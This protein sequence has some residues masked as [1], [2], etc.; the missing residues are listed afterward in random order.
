MCKFC[1][2]QSIVHFYDFRLWAIFFFDSVQHS[3][4]SNAENIQTHLPRQYPTRDNKKKT[5]HIYL[6]SNAQTNIKINI[7]TN[8]KKQQ[9]QPNCEQ[10][11]K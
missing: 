5:L 1:Q 10:A 3:T 11:K 2:L 8:E 9:Q 4:F 7:Y 6:Q